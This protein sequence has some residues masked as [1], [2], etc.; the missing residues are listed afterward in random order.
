MKN[1][2]KNLWVV[3]MSVA[4]LVPVAMLGMMGTYIIY[5]LTNN[6]VISYIISSVVGGCIAAA[7][8]I[9]K[10]AT[11]EELSKGKKCV[12]IVVA[13]LLFSIVAFGVSGV[14]VAV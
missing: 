11:S 3:L 12:V 8:V 6:L 14:Q 4:L 13:I 1:I 9:V 7:P 5:M 10:T 2:L